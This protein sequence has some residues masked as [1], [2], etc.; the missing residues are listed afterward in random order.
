MISKIEGIIITETPYGE[1][2]KII[3]IL[4][5]THGMVGVMC[6][7][8]KS[9]KNPLRV[10]TLKFTYGN[11]HLKYNENNGT[12]K[13]NAISF[14]FLSFGNTLLEV[15]TIEFINEISLKM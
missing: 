6:T 12:Y 11:F 1:N 7:N 10:K 13:D 14:P 9:I 3:N 15:I 2:S 5:P 4:T 8:A